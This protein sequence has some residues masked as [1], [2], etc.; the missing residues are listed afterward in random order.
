MS[1]S[2]NIKNILRTLRDK[3]KISITSSVGS[4]VYLAIRELEKLEDA[5]DIKESYRAKLYGYRK[6]LAGLLQIDTAKEEWWTSSDETKDKVIEGAIAELLS[7]R[8]RQDTP[9]GKV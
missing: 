5:H 7:I 1:R 2:S 4:N 9:A 8:I 6:W 3:K